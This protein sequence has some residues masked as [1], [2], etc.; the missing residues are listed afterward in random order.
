VEQLSIDFGPAPAP[1]FENFWVGSNQAAVSAVRQLNRPQNGFQ[2]IVLWGEFGSGRTHLIKSCD[3]DI[4]RHWTI[5]DANSPLAAFRP[6]PT[7]F[8]YALDDLDQFSP[9]HLQASFALWVDLQQRIDQPARLL[10][11][12]TKAP[13]TLLAEGLR[14]DLASRLAQSLVFE[15]KPLGDEDKKQAL[16]AKFLERGLQVSV[17]V[18]EFL[19]SRLPRSMA[20]L[21]G[22]LDALDQLGLQS[23]RAIT[24]PLLREW[25]KQRHT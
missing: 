23:K 16:K 19:I 11:T 12:T 21:T 15:L 7:Q 5:L 6:E 10:A 13:A 9:E 1:T 17:E 20:S 8:A 14:A 18:L 3:Q 2:S 4:P 22:A 25:L 24:M